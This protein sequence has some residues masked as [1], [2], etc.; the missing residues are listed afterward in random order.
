MS[1]ASQPDKKNVEFGIGLMNNPLI[2]QLY[3][4]LSSAVTD[5]L[6]RA[7][8]SASN[9]Q[10]VPKILAKLSSH[11]ITSSPFQQEWA[12]ARQNNDGMIIRYRQAIKAYA[13]IYGAAY[14][15][16]MNKRP[17]GSKMRYKN[18]DRFFYLML[19]RA[20]SDPVVTSLTFFTNPQSREI[21]MRTL[22]LETLSNVVIVDFKDLD[23]A[24]NLTVVGKDAVQVAQQTA[25]Q[26]S[27]PQPEP[28]Q[29]LINP[30]EEDDGEISLA[31]SRP[32]TV[33]TKRS[34]TSASVF[35]SASF[36]DAKG[37]LNIMGGSSGPKLIIPR[38]PVPV[39]EDNQSVASG[40]EDEDEDDE[41]EENAT[42]GGQDDGFNFL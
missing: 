36:V 22:F 39:D 34:A 42:F 28:P 8:Q 18:M 13:G 9:K 12:I 16:M 31:P 35:D 19:V 29:Q 30:Y 24:E 37:T 4:D 33:L 25:P 38:V 10:N 7:Y 11:D 21:L 3:S 27:Q 23:E 14:A 26:A 20:A 5:V 41:E 1:V 2:Q 17:K 32:G 15:K 40:A 6:N